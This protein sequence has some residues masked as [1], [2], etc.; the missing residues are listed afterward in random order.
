MVFSNFDVEFAPK[1]FCSLGAGVAFNSLNMSARAAAAC[2]A[3]SSRIHPAHSLRE[4]ARDSEKAYK[5]G[6]IAEGPNNDESV[7]LVAEQ[8]RASCPTSWLL[9]HDSSIYRFWR[10][11][12][13]VASIA[14]LIIFPLEL[15]L[16]HQTQMERVVIVL[17]VLFAIDIMISFR[18]SFADESTGR[19]VVESKAIAKHYATG[20]FMP[21]VLSV[22]PVFTMLMTHDGPIALLGF[23]R[24]LR[25]RHILPV[26]SELEKM[27][28]LE[29][30]TTC[31]LKF[32]L[33]L[34]LDAHSGGCLMWFLASLRD[35]REGETW[36]STEL[37]FGAS[38]GEQYTACIYWAVTTLTT[39]G[40]GDYS[41]VSIEERLFGSLYMLFNMGILAY[42]IGMV[43]SLSTRDG[44]AAILCFSF[45]CSRRRNPGVKL[46]FPS[47]PFII[48]SGSSLA[49][50]RGP[51]ASSDTR[52][53]QS[54]FASIDHN[55]QIK[56]DSRLRAVRFLRTRL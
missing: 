22:F 35:F 37:A 7:A 42:I 26:F 43:S 34:L 50:K 31:L 24:L 15:A 21:D 25:V 29:Y 41:P 18:L 49:V 3:W 48:A 5:V 14:S 33:L 28:S 38:V 16:V 51:A 13:L 47:M 1:Y 4:S 52:P 53:K 19:F 2:A 20:Y 40:Y 44:C 56:L 30:T 46:C 55:L 8:Q 27:E 10:R 45:L 11:V 36:V 9:L 39:V 54:N 6:F 17:D 23:L 32:L 12:L